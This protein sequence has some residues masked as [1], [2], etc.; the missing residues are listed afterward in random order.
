MNKKDFQKKFPDIKLQQLST[1]FVFSRD[2][3]E[4]TVLKLVE[5]LNTG[6]VYYKYDSK[7]IKVF[8]SDAFQTRLERMKR[9][10][11]V[12]HLGFYGTI[13]CEKPFLGTTVSEKPF[14]ICGSLYIRVAFNNQIDA[15]NCDFF[16]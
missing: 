5:G 10:D 15:Y 9:G 16:M 7:T 1:E 4:Y 2:K 3:V 12:F 11:S 6:L 13:V 8:T 14:L